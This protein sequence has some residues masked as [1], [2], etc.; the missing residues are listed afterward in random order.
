MIDLDKLLSGKQ[1]NRLI[2]AKSFSTLRSDGLSAVRIALSSTY[3]VD[4]SSLCHLKAGN[5]DEFLKVMR[6]TGFYIL[7]EQ[8][9][10]MYMR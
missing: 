4:G 9:L 6:M 5:H 2:S 7:K 1:T 10:A 8:V 3:S